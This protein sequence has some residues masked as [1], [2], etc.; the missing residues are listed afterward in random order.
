[1]YYLLIRLA[2]YHVKVL[3][4]KSYPNNKGGI[5]SMGQLRRG[6]SGSNIYAAIG[7]LKIIKLTLIIEAHH[8]YYHHNKT[9]L[10]WYEFLN[11]VGWNICTHKFCLSGDTYI[12]QWYI[13]LDVCL[14]PTCS[15]G[16]TCTWHLCVTCYNWSR[17]VSQLTP[18]TS[19][20]LFIVL[21][22][23]LRILL[24]GKLLCYIFEHCWLMQQKFM[25]RFGC[26]Y[27]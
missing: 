17:V 11:E 12:T 4:A 10:F 21:C 14:N 1:M 9:T 5:E 8:I 6:Q 16:C 18:N 20:E 24:T 13:A 15:R 23:G 2:A 7:D 26:K 25:C 19:V 3:N 27:L 22:L